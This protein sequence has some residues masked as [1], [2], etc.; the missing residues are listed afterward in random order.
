MKLSRRIFFTKSTHKWRLERGTILWLLLTTL[1]TAL[2]A[3][4]VALTIKDL[5]PEIPLFY[6]LPWGESRLTS[7]IWLWILP[8][9]SGVILLIN[10]LISQF[11]FETVLSRILVATTTLVALMS[12]I[13]LGKIILLGQP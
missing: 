10:L 3:G 9:V 2:A 11:L 5:P 1:L 4:L 6:S 13:S 8:A 7:P 12:L